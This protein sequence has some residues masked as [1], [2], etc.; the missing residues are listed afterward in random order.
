MSNRLR[1]A[2]ITAAASF[3]MGAGM[4]FGADDGG[5]ADPT[6]QELIDQINTLKSQV[7]QLQA[8]QEAQESKLTAREVDR[9]MQ[10]VLA[11]ADRRSQ[12]MQAQGFTAGYS[13]GKF[14]IQS[15]DGNFVLNP[16]LQMQLRYVVNYREEDANNEIDGQTKTEEGLELRR[17][18]LNFEGNVFGPDNTFK[19]QWAT[20]RNTGIPEI[21]EAWLKHRFTGFARDFLIRGGA[22]KDVT[23]HEE[24]NSSKR[25]LAVERSLVNHFLGGSQTKYIQG[26]GII[27]DDGPDGLPLRGEIG[28]SDGGFS[29]LTSFQKGRG[30]SFLGVANPDFAFY[31][32]GEYLAFGD[33]KSYE[34]HTALGNA[35]DLLVL[36]A[37]AYYTQAGTNSALQHTVDAQWEVGRLGIY[38][39]YLGVASDNDDLGSGYNYGF[40]GQAAYLLTDKWEPFVRYDYIHLDNLTSASGEDTFHEIT[41]GVNYYMTRSHAAKLTVDVVYLPN[42]APAS[43]DGLGILAPDAGDSQFVFRSQFQL[44]L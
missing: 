44:L 2:A 8:K 34:D 23:F 29:N 20:N 5:T 22:F 6:T 16:Q 26:V 11:D 4:V 13:K 38:G 28:Y 1:A 17:L 27:W 7:E 40:L 31:A 14:L 10:E 3:G 19:F 9:T 15:E 18:K 12:L 32:R 37:G 39:A 24:L 36:G 25:L 35:T 30:S 42:G 43:T 33:W 41:A 21:E